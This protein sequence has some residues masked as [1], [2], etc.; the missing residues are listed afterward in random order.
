WGM[1]PISGGGLD[2]QK[3]IRLKEWEEGEFGT[4]T[5]SQDFMPRVIGDLINCL[6]SKDPGQRPGNT[7]EYIKMVTAIQKI[8]GSLSI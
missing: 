2:L 5:L 3:K 6:L 8:V 1:P 4:K 7:V